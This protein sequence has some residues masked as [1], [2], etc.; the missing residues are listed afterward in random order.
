L[1][2]SAGREVD[3]ETRGCSHW[4]LRKVENNS[5]Y[6]QRKVIKRKYPE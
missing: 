2:H 1:A 5:R 3:Q 6:E 4:K